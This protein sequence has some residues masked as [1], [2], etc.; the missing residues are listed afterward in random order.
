MDIMPLQLEVSELPN[1]YF[2][3]EA[4]GVTA[5]LASEHAATLNS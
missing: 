1:P 3:R 5:R 4:A 2:P